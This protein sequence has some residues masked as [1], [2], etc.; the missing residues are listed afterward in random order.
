MRFWGSVNTHTERETET[1]TDLK[2]SLQRV[3]G[4]KEDGLSGNRAQKGVAVPYEKSSSGLFHRLER[5]R[6]LSLDLLA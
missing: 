3:D 2:K 1:E 6:H 4:V 5:T